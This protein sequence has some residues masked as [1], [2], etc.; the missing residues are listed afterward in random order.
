MAH[1][2]PQTF[3]ERYTSCAKDLTINEMST[4]LKPIT[5]VNLK[6]KT[7]ETDM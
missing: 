7:R 1:K 2:V 5:H 3:K 4:S 6:E